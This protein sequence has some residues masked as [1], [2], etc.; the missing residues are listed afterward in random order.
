LSEKELFEKCKVN[1]K[2]VLESLGVDSKKVEDEINRQGVKIGLFDKRSVFKGAYYK[3]DEQ[4][5]IGL[6]ESAIYE[7]EC[8]KYLAHEM[9]HAVGL[10]DHHWFAEVQCKFFG[11]CKIDSRDLFREVPPGECCF[12]KD[13]NCP[14][15]DSQCY[16]DL[17]KAS[18]VKKL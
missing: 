12:M 8:G 7:P 3:K 5:F 16:N 11:R 9:L 10:P 6:D 15:L 1:A 18:F 4:W 2:K 13:T 17:K 14:R